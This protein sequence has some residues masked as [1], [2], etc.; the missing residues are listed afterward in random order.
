MI[1]IYKITNPKGK[2]YIGQSINIERRFKEH[3]RYKKQ[4]Y[5]NKLYNSFKKYN[6]DNHNF[7]VI[8]EC[9]V[10]IL[11]ERERHWQEF[12]DCVENG[13]NIQYTKTETR[14][15]FLSEYHKQLL[16]RPKNKTLI[17]KALEK[18]NPIIINLKKESVI[19]LK[20]TII[21]KDKKPKEVFLK[22]KP[23][24]IIKKINIKVKQKHYIL[25]IINGI[26]YNSFTEASLYCDFSSVTLIKM[27]RGFI[28]NKTNYIIV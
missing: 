25:D 5:K 24:K 2:I 27:L 21:I 1:G 8:E 12:Y 3:K 7:E 4:G 15:G 22:I 11:N 28:K 17:K 14:S 10:H 23:I 19:K 9:D 13:L 16:R 6:Y 20:K 18:D 26:Y